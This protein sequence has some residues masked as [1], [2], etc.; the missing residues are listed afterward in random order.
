MAEEKCYF[1][2]KPTTQEDFCYGCQ[3]YICEECNT[4]ADLPFGK[5]K[6]EDHQEEE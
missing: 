1:C 3:Q 2:N 6:V 5:H 4:N